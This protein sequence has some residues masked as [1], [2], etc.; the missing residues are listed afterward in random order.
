M[1]DPKITFEHTVRELLK[2]RSPALADAITSLG[3]EEQIWTVIDSLSLLD[4][5]VSL[6]EHF[7]IAIQPVE[8]VPE[9][10]RTIAQIVRFLGKRTRRAE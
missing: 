2:A 7:K 9:N 10:F 3:V 4:L 8:V 5:V 6:E 1:D